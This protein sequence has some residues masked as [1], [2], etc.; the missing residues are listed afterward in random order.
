[1]N[2]KLQL[3]QD[4]EIV[5]RRKI[6]GESLLKFFFGVYYHRQNPAISLNELQDLIAIN[7]S[8]DSLTHLFTSTGIP[9]L[10]SVSPK[11]TDSYLLTFLPSLLP[12]SM[13]LSSNKDHLEELELVHSLL[14]SLLP[15]LSELSS[16]PATESSLSIFS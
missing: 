7:T 1:L 9:H 12:L 11:S 6:L 8:T 5:K 15:L 4:E 10:L 2:L 3:N 16:H 14:H 13:Q